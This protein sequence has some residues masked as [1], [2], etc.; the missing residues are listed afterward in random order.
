MTAR[1]LEVVQLPRGA[2]LS[3]V[4]ATEVPHVAI[5]FPGQ[6]LMLAD[7]RK[8]CGCASCG[9]KGCRGPYC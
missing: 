9:E 8:G 7:G 2:A 3:I 1:F 5:R 6:Q 4:H